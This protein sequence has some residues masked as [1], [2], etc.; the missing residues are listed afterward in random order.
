MMEGYTYC[1]D[2]LLAGAFAR[3]QKMM[4]FIDSK[5]DTDKDKYYQAAKKNSRFKSRFVTGNRLPIRMNVIKALGIIE[6]AK[7][8]E[9]L[10]KEMF[11][12]ASRAFKSIYNIFEDTKRLEFDHGFM[13]EVFY[14]MRVGQKKS[15]DRLH[16]AYGLYMYFCEKYDMEPDDDSELYERVVPVVEGKEYAYMR[17]FADIGRDFVKDFEQEK[18]VKKLMESTAGVCGGKSLEDI[19]ARLNPESPEA[20]LYTMMWDFAQLDN[21]PASMYESERFTNKEL[22]D[23]F[24]A[25]TL[26]MEKGACRPEDINHYYVAGLYMRSFAR[27]YHEAEA[28]VDAYAGIVRETEQQKSLGRELSKARHRISELEKLNEEKQQALNDIQLE[29]DRAKKKTAQ[30]DEDMAIMA[31][32]V[33][34]LQQ[35]LDEGAASDTKDTGEMDEAAR[36]EI[37]ARAKNKKAVV[38]G[39]HPNWQAEVRKAAP[40][41]TIIDPDNYGFDVK[42][43]DKVDVIVIKTDYMAHA[44]WYKI[45]ERA[46]KKGKKII[47]CTNSVDDMLMKIGE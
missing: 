10:D 40:D 13:E 20:G 44:Q 30:H 1:N 4:R 28:I 37:L 6:V 17:D 24:N 39:G 35:L 33:K 3:S 23:I 31:E 22:Q 2:A 41:F 29:L 15:D 19:G 9:A 18:N 38:F 26:N 47:F 45:T 8:D 42:I 16:D 25:I 27:L 32:R 5:Y 34:I 14:T 21:V 12:A 11:E 7:S 46:K 43:I 36:Q